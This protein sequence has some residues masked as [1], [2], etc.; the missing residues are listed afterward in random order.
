M[1]PILKQ[2]TVIPRWG[3]FRE[4][5]HKRVITPAEVG[6]LFTTPII[7]LPA[8]T[9]VCLAPL[10]GAIT[11]AAGAYTI[12]NQSFFLRWMA[13]SPINAFAP[14]TVTNLALTSAGETV[15]FTGGQTPNRQI[16]NAADQPGEKRLELSLQTSNP[17]GDLGGEIT[18][19]LGYLKIPC[20]LGYWANF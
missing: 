5:I 20:N 18:F 11:K 3:G 13:S 12:T 8:E 14:N 10:W 6:V 9:G 7:F 15:Y 1:P 16:T 19:I 17:T 2:T 4:F